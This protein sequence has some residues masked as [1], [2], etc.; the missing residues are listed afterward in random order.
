MVDDE[1][2][3]EELKQDHAI[4][5]IILA[6]PCSCDANSSL[7]LSSQDCPYCLGDGKIQYGIDEVEFT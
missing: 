5:S 7:G 6:C 2:I 4:T 1:S 3:I